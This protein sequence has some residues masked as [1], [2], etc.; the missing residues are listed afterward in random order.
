MEIDYTIRLEQE[1]DYR[2]TENLTREAFW[3]V[4]R[5]GCVEHYVL[6]KFRDRADFIRKLS[7][8]MEKDGKLIGHIMYA[9]SKIECGDGNSVPIVTFGPF[10]ILPKEQ[11][12]GYGT[13][14]LR[15][16]MDR[17]A[18][19][20]A[21][22]IAITGNADFYRKSGFVIAKNIG[23]RYADD[24]DADYFLIRELQDG[25]LAKCANGVY[26]DP[27][28]YFVDEND[29]EIFDRTFPHKEKLKTDTQL[30]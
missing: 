8:V 23:I 2:E 29:A 28:G 9:D 16:S 7:F 20:G 6:H 13:A 27:D 24:F 15:Y 18:Q 19:L 30:F 17:S 22:A 10:S 26:R 3:N 12:K 5:P 14:L 1:S 11:G 25:F 4:Y 21:G